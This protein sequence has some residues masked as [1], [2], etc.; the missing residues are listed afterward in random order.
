M[1]VTDLTDEEALA[2]VVLHLANE[3]CDAEDQSRQRRN[4]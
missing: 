2:D 4:P 1:K 3:I